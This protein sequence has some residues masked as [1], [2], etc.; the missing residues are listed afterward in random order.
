VAT[1]KLAYNTDFTYKIAYDGGRLRKIRD[2]EPA[3]SS[4][5][6]SQAAQ[7]LSDVGFLNLTNEGYSIT[8][9][10]AEALRSHGCLT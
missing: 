1:A 2:T 9:A 6:V 4:P 5:R 8:E 3:F 10:G 7:M